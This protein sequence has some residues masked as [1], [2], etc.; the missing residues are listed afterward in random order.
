[1]KSPK[2]IAVLLYVPFLLAATSLNAV[3][4]DNRAE[5]KSKKP[6]LTYY[7]FDG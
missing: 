5:V 3:E 7:Y 1:M 2:M 4:V 6:S